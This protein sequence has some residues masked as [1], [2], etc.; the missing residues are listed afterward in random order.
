M[1][2][3]F[4]CQCRNGTRDERC[5]SQT[6]PLRSHLVQFHEWSH[7]PDPLTITYWDPGQKRFFS[8]TEWGGV[9]GALKN[10]SAFLGKSS[11][12]LIILM[13]DFDLQSCQ[14]IYRNEEEST[15]YYSNDV[16]YS[17]LR[18]HTIMTPNAVVLL[19]DWSKQVRSTCF[20]RELHRYGDSHILPSYFAVRVTSKAF[21]NEIGTNYRMHCI[22]V[23]LGGVACA[24]LARQYE[25]RYQGRKF[26]RIVALDP[27]QGSFDPYM[28]ASELGGFAILMSSSYTISPNQH[29]TRQLSK[30]DA[31]YVAVIASSFGSLGPSAPMGDE[32][33]LTNVDGKS[34]EA[35]S[36]AYWWKNY[37]CATSFFGKKHC[38][39]INLGF[40]FYRTYS[41]CS[42]LMAVLSFM[43]S[44]DVTS[45]NI[46]FDA[47]TFEIS[48]WNAY[49]V[50]KDITHSN[51]FYSKTTVTNRMNA[52]H[53][54][55]ES[56][57]LLVLV[58]VGAEAYL[59]TS[60]PYITARSG[61]IWERYYFVDPRADYDVYVSSGG[62]LRFARLY[63]ATSV[64]NNVNVKHGKNL[65]PMT[66]TKT[67]EMK[68]VFQYDYYVTGTSYYRCS[69]TNDYVIEN[70]YRRQLNV[71]GH[72]INFPEVCQC[73]NFTGF[74]RSMLEE[75]FVA[76]KAIVGQ[77]VSLNDVFKG[78]ANFKALAAVRGS[79]RHIL[80]TYWS[81]CHN[82][83]GSGVI[84]AANRKSDN[85][86]ARFMVSGKVELQFLFEL[87]TVSVTFEV[88]ERVGQRGRRSAEVSAQDKRYTGHLHYLY[89]EYGSGEPPM[90]NV[91]FWLEHEKK[92]LELETNVHVWTYL[93]GLELV[94]ADTRDIIIL[95]PD[96]VDVAFEDRLGAF[97][98]AYEHTIAGFKS[99]LRMHQRMTP[100]ALVMLLDWKDQYEK[101]PI[102]IRYNYRD[103][104][105]IAMR[106][107]VRHLLW[108]MKGFRL[109]CVGHSNGAHAC[110]SVC[111]Q[112]SRFSGEKC[113]RI[114]GLDPASYGFNPTL[115]FTK[116][117]EHMM[118]SR[119]DA[120]Y[121]VVIASSEGSFYGP[122]GPMG[123]EYLR[124]NLDGKSH[125]GCSGLGGWWGRICCQSYTGREWC[126]DLHIH[127][128]EPDG[129]VH[130]SNAMCS[131]FTVFATFMR[132][133]DVRAPYSLLKIEGGE[134]LVSGWSAYVL[135][136][137][138]THREH[139]KKSVPDVWVMKGDYYTLES[140]NL[141]RI[142]SRHYLAYL[143]NSDP[144]YSRKV[145]SDTYVR[146]YFTRLSDDKDI[147]LY[148]KGSIVSV[149]LYIGRS[150]VYAGGI[151]VVPMTTHIV[152]E[153]FCDA[154]FVY[155]FTGTKH[156][157]CKF[158][159]LRPVVPHY[160]SM[161]NVTVIPALQVPP[162]S[163]CL[164]NEFRSNV[165]DDIPL[166]ISEILQGEWIDLSHFSK[167]PDLQAVDVVE[168][169]WGK[170][171]RLVTF[172]DVCNH[173]GGGILV[174]VDAE[175]HI[176]RMRFDIPGDYEVRFYY[177]QERAR[178][179]V[180]VHMVS[181]T[182]KPSTPVTTR[183]TLTSAVSTVTST[184]T[185]GSRH[186]VLTTE[187]T[188]ISET[189]ATS[190][191]SS[192]RQEMTFL[193]LLDEDGSSSG[194]GS[195]SD[196]TETVTTQKGEL[197]VERKV[198][199]ED[200]SG[201]AEAPAVYLAPERRIGGR[202]GF[203]E[204]GAEPY[205]DSPNT[206]GGLV[207]TGGLDSTTVAMIVTLTL[208]C[209]ALILAV[210]WCWWQWR[211]CTLR[212][213]EGG[214]AVLPRDHVDLRPILTQE[215][216]CSK[217]ENPE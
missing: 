27:P 16:M 116:G 142:E 18:M 209:T 137:D 201:D 150:T 146:W 120:D 171:W 105:A 67:V 195:A 3:C 132:A 95:I 92:F 26:T 82:V 33:L 165:Y 216:S 180:R 17:L 141:L 217:N 53:D 9:V 194:D 99:L 30:E 135:G 128:R 151:Q 39:Y 156:Y 169:V 60:E 70:R 38:E 183:V 77:L 54:D 184:T 198:N 40:A 96:M 5:E 136:K 206:G 58:S 192:V 100:N 24:S 124:V 138:Y 35:C 114:V 47:K 173:S 122:W 121:V 152:R 63:T 133:L 158:Y 111:R 108:K 101:M 107:D 200:F 179:R 144:Y 196:S 140:Y 110:A 14:Y 20:Y 85:L 119:H 23:S 36:E 94:K 81:L 159:S 13:Q 72:V 74:Y 154:T 210:L 64:L 126:E 112:Y 161:L 160:R 164:R 43:K 37:I 153:P 21:I 28:S 182:T 113:S 87:H 109:H 68:C 89:A 211:K 59:H 1:V 148:S 163:G 45:G 166:H 86:S 214:T 93:R 155:V 19:F 84:L 7:P 66:G 4:S 134:F 52:R 91:I 2:A 11:G 176:F 185:S 157:V 199:D 178:G 15:F 168:Y 149:K 203:D 197:H 215:G 61:A 205:T 69:R 76:R 187:D 204:E 73:L 145:N 49:T 129:A 22:G 34:H 90:P 25:G 118:L 139:Y 190:S 147:V 10:T 106:F 51:T 71:T 130:M 56:R 41:E 75:K 191:N 175:K 8:V 123:D 65:V 98:S 78:R 213:V 42:H 208:E 207:K 12:E 6:K 188:V 32:M 48:S 102:E 55:M 174:E 31:E 117:R 103:P 46:L 97:G 170:T 57:R 29:S 83:S 44:L 62:K 127:W 177:E 167:K 212:S 80:M 125:D 181:T 193:E 115:Y 172:W 104:I 162:V 186:I 143:D 189:S 79:V 202:F 131:H 88:S 50:S